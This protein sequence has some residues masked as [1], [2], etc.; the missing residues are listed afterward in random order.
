MAV[1]LVPIV[2]EVCRTRVKPTPS[3]SAAGSVLDN[4][5]DNDLFAVDEFLR[6]RE[7]IHSRRHEK[8][9]ALRTP[10]PTFQLVDRMQIEL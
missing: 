10:T 9:I 7:K 4:D 8:A 3:E 6:L 1:C 5:D 2:I